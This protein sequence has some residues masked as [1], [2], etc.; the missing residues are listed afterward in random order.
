MLRLITPRSDLRV[1]AR[2]SS[3][4]HMR[5]P[6]ALYV[7]AGTD[8]PLSH[9]PSSH[10]LVC[11]DGQPFSEFG[12]LT[13]DCHVE[14]SCFSRPSFIAHLK[15]SASRQGLTLTMG[16]ESDVLCFGD[17]V[18]YYTNTSMPDHVT[19]LRG[20]G[21]FSTLVVRGH[22]PH[23]NVAELLHP[24][25]NSF[26]GFSGTLYTPR[27]DG[28]NTMVNLLHECSRSRSRFRAFTLVRGDATRVHCSD[29]FDFVRLSSESH[30]IVC[31]MNG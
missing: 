4:S 2:S 7:G 30:E 18:R 15:L 22:H 19:R 28:E 21:P 9:I 27:D 5:P 23:R 1:S 20:E 11:V 31:D 3:E 14:T 25:E 16:D 24:R 17:R 8:I 6:A 12:T 10:R 13:C 29:W 26:L